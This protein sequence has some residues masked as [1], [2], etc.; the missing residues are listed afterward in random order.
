MKKIKETTFTTSL[1]QI[2]DL[3]KKAKDLFKEFNIELPK[4]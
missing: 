3:T 4:T 1:T 2:S